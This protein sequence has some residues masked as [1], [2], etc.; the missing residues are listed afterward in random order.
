MIDQI[1]HNGFFR[2]HRAVLKHTAIRVRRHA[3][4]RTVDENIGIG[5]GIAKG[6]S[7]GQGKA[8]RGAIGSAADELSQ[9]VGFVLAAIKDIDGH[10]AVQSRL[11]GNRSGGA[12]RSGHHNALSFHI[13]AMGFEVSHFPDTVGNVAGEL[14]AVIDDGIDRAD[15]FGRRR[16]FVNQLCHLGFVRHGQIPADGAHFFKPLGDRGQILGTN[17]KSQIPKVEAQGV[18]SRVV[19]GRR[20]TVGH[21]LTEQTNEAG[22]S[23]DGTTFF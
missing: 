5:K 23:V 13:R 15:Q 19:H 7:I 14:S 21:R 18:K 3:E 20:Q 16:E 17:I 22:L 8:P 4:E 6:F 1:G 10:R 11:H 9:R 12:S 2:Q